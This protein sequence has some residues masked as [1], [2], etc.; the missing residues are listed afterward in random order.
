MLALLLC[1]YGCS[2]TNLPLDKFEIS[3]AIDNVDYSKGEPKDIKTFV[4][5]YFT[6]KKK[7]FIARIT[8]NNYDFIQNVTRD[9]DTNVVYID[10]YAHLY[11]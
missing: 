6:S 5:D 7:G 2:A 3:Y 10:G 1:S 9:E 4:E 8:L 11:V